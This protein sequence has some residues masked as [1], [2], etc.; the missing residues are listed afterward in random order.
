MASA[1]V[2]P[3]PLTILLAD[4]MNWQRF[5][6]SVGDTIHVTGLSRDLQADEQRVG[7]RPPVP[8][9]QTGERRGPVE[10]SLNVSQLWLPHVLTVRDSNELR[11]GLERLKPA[12]V[13]APQVPVT[14]EKRIAWAETQI[15]RGPGLT[16][17]GDDQ[18]GGVLLAMHAIGQVREARRLWKAIRPRA[19]TH[20]N[21]ISLALL[22]AAAR[23]LGGEAIHRAIN[24]I[25]S[26]GAGLTSALAEVDRIGHSSGRDTL[27]GVVAVLQQATATR[28]A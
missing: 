26:G 20:T 17:S 2:A 22:D 15:G 7:R 21:E 1:E 13:S 23:G 5:G 10:I 24:A 9:G 3:G 27:A 6:L 14:L 16:P 19:L 28:A 11:E 4:R 12:Y 8:P 25:F 18:I